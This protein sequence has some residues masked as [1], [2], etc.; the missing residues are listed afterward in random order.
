MTRKKE[1]ITK[2]DPPITLYYE[3]NFT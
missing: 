3:N 1:E 2:P